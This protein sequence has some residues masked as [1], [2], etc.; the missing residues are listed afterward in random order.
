MVDNVGFDAR[1]TAELHDTKYN[2]ELLIVRPR[3]VLLPPFPDL[4]CKEITGGS[5]LG[6]VLL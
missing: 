3:P 5:Q 4:E 2:R 1:N 6:C